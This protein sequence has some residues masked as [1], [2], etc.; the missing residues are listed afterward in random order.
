M[1]QLN[2]RR[3]WSEIFTYLNSSPNPL[4]IVELI[5][6]VPPCCWTFEFTFEGTGRTTLHIDCAHTLRDNEDLT[7]IDGSLIEVFFADSLSLH[8]TEE[9]VT[10]DICELFKNT[11]PS[12]QITLR[13]RPSQG[14]ESLLT[15]NGFGKSYTTPKELQ[16]IST[17]QSYLWENTWLGSPDFDGSRYC[18]RW[19]VFATEYIIQPQ[20]RYKNKL[21]S[22]D[23]F[24]T[25]TDLYNID[26]IHIGYANFYTAPSL[27]KNELYT[28][29]GPV[30]P[31]KGDWLI[32]KNKDPYWIVEIGSEALKQT[33]IRGG[34]TRKL[35]N[36]LIDSLEN[37]R[38][39]VTESDSFQDYKRKMLWK[40]E[41]KAADD[42]RERQERARSGPRVRLN[43]KPVMLIPSNE[44]EVLLLLAKL[45][46]LNALPFH[47]FIL[48][49]HTPRTGIDAIASYQM[50]EIDEQSMF[51]PI[52]LEYHFENFD[53]HGHPYHQ[54]NL[55]TCWDFRDNATASRLH[56]HNEWLYEY[57]NDASF[58]VAVLSRIPDLQIEEN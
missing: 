57:R 27:K 8:R 21:G 13:N 16:E 18:I 49:E 7:L 45:E 56:K 58:F 4:R 36:Q 29:F 15:L 31:E 40:R 37:A 34:Y 22:T 19:R 28:L 20:N 1:M 48:W 3:T 32:T 5:N 12:N 46:T 25:Q 51:V 9:S 50:R 43:G 24:T 30:D 44:N 6:R 35:I 14:K 33:T 26:G 47:E 11:P 55:V 41:S 39:S 23:T 54:V 17:I 42:L 38:I 2:L 10:V 53:D 52:E